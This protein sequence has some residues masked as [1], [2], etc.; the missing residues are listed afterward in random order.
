MVQACRT[1]PTS[2]SQ[3]VYSEAAVG[4][5]RGLS[6]LVHVRIQLL[7]VTAAARVSQEGPSYP[8]MW[9]RKGKISLTL[10]GFGA[11]LIAL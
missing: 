1:A 4:Q 8:G 6:T 9:E 2:A 10:A 7:F 3:E 11:C 5:R